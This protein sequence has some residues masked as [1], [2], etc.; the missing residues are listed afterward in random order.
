VVKSV[1]SEPVAWRKILPPSSGLEMEATCSSEMLVDF[2]RTT[3]HCI[4]EDI[5]FYTKYL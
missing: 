1:K 4:P 3:W 5:T 2:Q